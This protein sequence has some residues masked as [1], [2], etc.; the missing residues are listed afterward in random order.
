[1]GST[2]ET[3]HPGDLHIEKDFRER[4]IAIKEREQVSREEELRLKAKEQQQPRWFNPLFLAL[5]AAAIAAAGNA[6]VAW[7]NSAAE[8]QLDQDK[9]EA[10]RILEAIKTGNPDDAATNLRFLMEAGL[11]SNPKIRAP[12]EKYLA[13][14]A[15][16]KGAALPSVQTSSAHS[17]VFVPTANGQ[18]MRCDYDQQT[19]QYSCH[20]ID[21]GTTPKSGGTSAK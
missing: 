20:L 14:R 5:L 16:G 9:S 17:P 18:V 13:D 10:Q 3:S 8:Q 19:G 4:E 15:T 6:I 2:N 21:A 7:H 12:L 11:V 1:M